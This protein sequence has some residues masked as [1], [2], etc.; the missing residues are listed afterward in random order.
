MTNEAETVRPDI[1]A[2]AYWLRILGISLFFILLGE[3][4]QTPQSVHW[5]VRI[6]YNAG[7]GITP[8]IFGGGIAYVL[9]KIGRRAG[10]AG[11][12]RPI[13]RIWWWTFWV[14]VFV[15]AAHLRSIYR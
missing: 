14:A 13:S 6:T 11:F 2:T 10:A 7:Y 5:T 15:L 9:H 1:R 4:T 12:E 3:F 8:V